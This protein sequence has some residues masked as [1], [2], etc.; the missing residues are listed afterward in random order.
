MGR[1]S[2]KGV[3]IGG[4]VDV[5]SSILLGIPFAVFAIL[6]VNF[7]HTP[8]D[9]VGAAV[10]AAIQENLRLYLGQLAIGLGCSTFGG[11]LAGRIA[12]HDELLNGLLS[13]FLCLSLGIFALSSHMDSHPL[14][15]KILLE[16]ASPAFALIGGYLALLR[17]RADTARELAA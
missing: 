17:R 1:I 14:V 12:K 2:I 16:I 8:K 11:Y 4:V 6:K 5:G 7:A 13:S 9:Q 15:V 3:L 10:T